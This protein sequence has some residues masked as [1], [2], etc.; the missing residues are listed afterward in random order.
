[1]LKT[2]VRIITDKRIV[3]LFRLILGITFVYA[4]LDKISNPDQFAR[5]IYNYHILPRFLINVYAVT[6]P[7]VELFAGLFLI[8]GVFTESASLLICFLLSVFIVAISINLFRGV[9]L[10]C[11]CFST[12]PAGAKE[13]AKLLIKDFV[14]LFLGIMIFFFNKSYVSLTALIP[15]KSTTKQ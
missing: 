2:L 6:L 3:L 14:F 5:I 15:N 13:G 11:G 12:D 4:S 9:N 8:F 7:W 1:M 10:N